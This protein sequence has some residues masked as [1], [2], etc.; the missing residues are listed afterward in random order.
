[1]IST[2]A[3][4]NYLLEQFKL[5]LDPQTRTLLTSNT[6]FTLTATQNLENKNNNHT[7]IN[8][9]PNTTPISNLSLSPEDSLSKGPQAI[10]KTSAISALLNKALGI[11]L[12]TETMKNCLSS[13]AE[14]IDL[15]SYC[16]P[17]DINQ[18]RDVLTDHA[19]Q[20]RIKLP[21]LLQEID[22]NLNNIRTPNPSSSALVAVNILA[23]V[24]VM[25]RSLIIDLK[26]VEFF[27]LLH[28]TEGLL[29]EICI[30]L[31]EEEEVI[32]GYIW[33]RYTQFK[34]NDRDVASMDDTRNFKEQI[35][36]TTKAFGENPI[37]A[38]VLSK[39]DP[40]SVNDPARE[41]KLTS[42]GLQTPKP[43]ET[44]IEVKDAKDLALQALQ[45]GNFPRAKEFY[46]E[47]VKTPDFVQLFSL[48][49]EMCGMSEL[50]TQ[51]KFSNSSSSSGSM[52]RKDEVKTQNPVVKQTAKP[53]EQKAKEKQSN[54]TETMPPVFS[55]PLNSTIGVMTSNQTTAI[56]VTTSAQTVSVITSET[57]AATDSVVAT[58][59]AK[60]PGPDVRLG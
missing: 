5:Y 32:N 2:H 10:E 55:S 22:D 9:S 50:N 60:I 30:S 40:K 41:G 49:A 21:K 20:M 44:K 29:T 35:E 51:P 12:E 24:L 1:M 57:I 13:H 56:S 58:E 11:K 53:S 27:P 47:A 31:G 26:Y 15:L 6:E 3:E 59:A 7:P 34:S 43:D 33:A 4:A 39:I 17:D 23:D 14:A 37:Y 42:A 36:R 45:E 52:D 16:N 25:S 28:K 8:Q 54:I 19:K 48:T 46:A 18:M 38:R